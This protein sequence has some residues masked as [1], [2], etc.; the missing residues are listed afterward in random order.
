[1]RAMKCEGT[2]QQLTLTCIVNT[3]SRGVAHSVRMSAMHVELE[4]VIPSE[5]S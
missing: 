1:M 3:A 5:S 2:T 4:G